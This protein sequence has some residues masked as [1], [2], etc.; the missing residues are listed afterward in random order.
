M[1]EAPPPW[2]HNR[3]GSRGADGLALVRAVRAAETV[4]RANPDE[5]RALADRRAAEVVKAA[6]TV[7]PYRPVWSGLDEGRSVEDMSELPTIGRSDLQDLPIE[8]R[9]T[10][11]RE[12]LQERSTSGTTGA[13]LL[14]LRTP[15]EGRFVDSI[16]WRQLR[17]QGVPPDARRL[18]IDFDRRR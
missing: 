17:A 16:V 14:V 7:E 6:R 13:P 3:A 12:G 18:S 9:L 5:I 8:S 15:E 10:R 1:S 11:P 2:R 4:L